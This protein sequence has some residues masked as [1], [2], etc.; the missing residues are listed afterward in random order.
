[1]YRFLGV[2]TDV[3]DAKKTNFSHV[4]MGGENFNPGYLGHIENVQIRLMALNLWTLKT[5][6]GAHTIKVGCSEKSGGCRFR[7]IRNGDVNYGTMP[8]FSVTSM[9][10]NLERMMT[11]SVSTLLRTI[12]TRVK[13]MKFPA[14]SRKR[15]HKNKSRQRRLVLC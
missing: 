6:K 10:F 4:T 15:V 8:V 11:I 2:G 7:M 3:H 14:E 12:F 5:W 9:A 13:A 1:M